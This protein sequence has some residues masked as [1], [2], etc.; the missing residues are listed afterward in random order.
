[1]DA[2]QEHIPPYKRFLDDVSGESSR[3]IEMDVPFITVWVKVVS[4]KGY[5]KRKVG[6][7]KS[8]QAAMGTENDDDDPTPPS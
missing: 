8:S 1:M 5:K 2:N 6:K 4:S 3:T 7:A